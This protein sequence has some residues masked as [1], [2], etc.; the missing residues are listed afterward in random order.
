[1]A[2]AEAD[3]ICGAGAASSPARVIPRGTLDGPL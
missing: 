2:A 3:L 1:M